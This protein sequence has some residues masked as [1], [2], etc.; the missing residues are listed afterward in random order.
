MQM[1][2][3]QTRTQYN[4]PTSQAVSGS[5]FSLSTD[6]SISYGPYD[7]AR[8]LSDIGWKA[9]GLLHISTWIYEMLEATRALF[10]PSAL[11]IHI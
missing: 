9:S 5:V 1:T 3:E 11:A 6:P 7:C 4:K 10:Y 8:E 2:S